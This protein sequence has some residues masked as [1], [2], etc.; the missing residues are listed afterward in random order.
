MSPEPMT[1]L[2]ITLII[3]LVSVGMAFQGK[4]LKSNLADKEKEE[5]HRLK[6]RA[7][8]L[9][10]CGAFVALIQVVKLVSFL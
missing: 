10:M 9:I 5:A 1:D 6:N 3:L 4:V 8:L 2:T 7:N